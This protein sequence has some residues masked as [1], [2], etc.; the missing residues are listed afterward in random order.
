M[1]QELEGFRQWVAEQRQQ[2]TAKAVRYP[3][4][5]RQWATHYARRRLQAGVPMVRVQ[6]ELTVS[7][8][9]LQRWLGTKSGIPQK[10]GATFREVGI[11]SEP[12]ERSR[13]SGDGGITLITPRGY[14]LEGL[15]PGRA[16]ALVRELG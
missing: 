4:E 12:R 2:K 6:Q 11:Q 15:D 7:S 3:A 13:A 16:I 14:R 8:P 9:A 5:K 1:D 10:T